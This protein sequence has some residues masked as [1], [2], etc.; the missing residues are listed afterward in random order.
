MKV[1][2]DFFSVAI[3]SALMLIGAAL[4]HSE[5]ATSV[6]PSANDAG[7]KEGA[8]D[9]AE[10]TTARDRA[11]LLHKVYASS[12]DMMH[13]RYFH[14]DKATVPARALEDVFKQLARETKIEARWI[15]VNAKVMSIN[16]E[17]KDD[18]EKSAAAALSAGKGSYEAVEDGKLRRATSIEL[19]AGCLSC[20]GTFGIEPKTPRFAGLVLTL[21]LKE[22][23]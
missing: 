23:E 16:H 15:G 17:P 5:D 19:H 11:K 21:P 4:V 20:H 18:F 6:S 10:L 7:A 13:D 8:P 1:R 22:Q 9:S 2:I 3:V 12:L 14:D